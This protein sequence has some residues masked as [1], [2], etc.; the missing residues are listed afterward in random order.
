[1]SKTVRSIFIILIVFSIYHTVRDAL[2]IAGVHNIIA[3]LANHKSNWCREIYPVCDYYL[4]PWE[5]FVLIGS[6]LVLKRNDVGLLGKLILYSLIVFPII[7][8]LNIV[9]T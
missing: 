3:D 7:L 9:L 5:F 2:Q 8:I 4:F 6:I 1:M